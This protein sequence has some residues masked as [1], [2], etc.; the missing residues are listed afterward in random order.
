MMAVST[1]TSK[2]QLTLP[3]A[4]RT[5]L[6]VQTGDTVDFVIEPDGTVVVRA[7]GSDVSA[8]R[9]LLHKVGRPA[10]TLEAM[11]DAI[12]EARRGPL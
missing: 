11:E 3:Q 4:I 8:L 6:R 10:V 2:G 1:L 12:R 7:G 9:G 5:R